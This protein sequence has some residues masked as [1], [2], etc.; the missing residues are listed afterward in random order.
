MRLVSRA[1]TGGWTSTGGASQRPDILAAAL[2]VAGSI[3]FF[4]PT[5][6]VLSVTLF[7]AG[8]LLF[9]FSASA[10][11]LLTH[12]PTPSRRHAV[13]SQS[14]A[15]NSRRR[16][17]QFHSGPPKRR[18]GAASCRACGSRSGVSLGAGGGLNRP[19]AA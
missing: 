2:F 11:A 19:L 17:T 10:A 18:S 13:A 1:S 15:A 3:G 5:R 16:F 8:S 7:L 6:Y 4:W 9:L 12:G 14:A